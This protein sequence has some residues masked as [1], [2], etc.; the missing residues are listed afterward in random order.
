MF[1]PSTFLFQGSNDELSENEEDLE[2]KSDSEG[3]DYSPNKKKKK[4]LKDKKE[5]KA[6][7]KKKDDDEDD[8]DDGCLKVTLT[9]GWGTLLGRAEPP[10][11]SSLPCR[12]PCGQRTR[13]S[14]PTKGRRGRWVCVCECTRRKVGHDFV[15]NTVATGLG[16]T[17]EITVDGT[18]EFGEEV[19]R[20]L[21]DVLSAVCPA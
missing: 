16:D 20:P 17:L 8:N 15:R 11:V 14:F 18:Q 2:E 21:A 19:V 9:P 7:R 12:S 10:A 13:A 1:S 3:S 6:K 4:K 5:K